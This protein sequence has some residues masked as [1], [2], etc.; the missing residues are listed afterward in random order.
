MM[1]KIQRFGGAMFTPVLFF[2]F[3]GIVVALAAVLN[4]PDIVGNIANEGTMWNSIWQIVE[5]G[6]WT[7]FNNMEILFAIGLPLGLANKASGRAALETFLL[8]MTFNSF[9]SKMLSLF[10][11]T[12]N[13][14]F[15]QDVGNGMKFIGGI[16]TLDTGV[17]GAI[18]VASIIIW[19]HNRYFE[20][21]LP[22]WLGIF[23]G[24]ALVGM[25]GFFIMIPTALI[26]AYIWP[27]FQSGVS[28]LQTFMVSSGNFGVFSYIFLEK[29]LLPFGLHHFIYAPFQFGPAVVE[30]GTTL[31]WMENLTRFAGST[32][33]LKE[34]FPEGG[35]ALQGLS[36]LFGIPGI[37][38][39]FYFT[40]KPENRKK[41]LALIVPGVLTAVFAG[42]TE[43]FDYTFLFIAPVLFLVHALLAATLAT[44]QY[45]FGVVGDMGGGL[46]EIITKNWVPMWNN[47]WNVY[48]TQIA[49]GLVFIVIYFVV[50]RYLITKF[51]FATPGRS[52][53]EV[54]LYTK[55]D[56]KQKKKD[57]NKGKEDS[58]LGLSFGE[59]A[60]GYLKA[61]GGEG[62]ILNVNNCAT[63]LRVSVNDENMLMDE[64][65]FLKYGAHGVVKN[66][67]AIQVIVGLSVTQVREEFDKLLGN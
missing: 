17:I 39:A 34:L 6:G 25:I 42:I 37:A 26:F 51:D 52:L 19:V 12:F 59:Q 13:V 45:I 50:F 4:N 35:F 56:Y 62:N 38:L 15:S 29:A 55:N 61:L 11:P 8:Y 28:S 2:V 14:D 46:I 21:K 20:K 48:L 33:P 40:S 16:K 36:N 47:H 1:A 7:V 53:E 58:G 5:E 44:T 24:S 27:I 65:E 64:K 43:P 49:I 10:G 18:I 31:Y 22:E 23:Q 3:S 32:Q 41:V 63:R 30:G 57:I 60:N 9:L 54:E 66:G 67:K